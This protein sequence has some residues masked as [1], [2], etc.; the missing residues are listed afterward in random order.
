MVYLP[1]LYQCTNPTSPRGPLPAPHAWKLVSEAGTVGP[2][3]SGS[4]FPGLCI[5][6][7]N[8]GSSTSPP[9]EMLKRNEKFLFGN[10]EKPTWLNILHP[11]PTV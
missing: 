10:T 4:H 5:E 7:Q 9:E 1:D 2:F 8:S 6:F 3:Q 11:V